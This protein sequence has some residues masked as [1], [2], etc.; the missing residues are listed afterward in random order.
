[1]ADSKELNE[2]GVFSVD[3]D[4]FERGLQQNANKLLA[5]R[6]KESEEKRLAKVRKELDALNAKIRRV[7][8]RIDSR[9]TKISVRATLHEQLDTLQDDFKRL[10]QDEQDILQR[11]NPTENTPQDF[12]SQLEQRE[13]LIRTGQITPFSRL[14]SVQQ[15]DEYEENVVE[16][17]EV[18]NAPSGSPSGEKEEEESEQ[19]NVLAENAVSSAV[20]EATLASLDDG[21]E[22]VYRKRLQK[23]CTA[24]QTLREKKEAAGEGTSENKNSQT[25]PESLSEEP[26]WFLPHP[27]KKAQVFDDGFSIPGDIRPKLFRYQ[28]TCILWLWE[29]Y[30][31]GAGGIIGDEMGLGK[32]VQIVAYLASLHYS[33]KFDKPT[34]VVCPATLMKQWVGEFHRWWAPFRVVILHS[35]GSGLNSKREGRDYKDSASEGEDE[36]EESVLEAEDERVNPLRR[37]SASFHKFAE[38]L[39]DSTFE[40]GHILI[41]TY[42]GLRI[43]SDLLLPREWGYCILDEGHKIRN[44]DAEISILSKQLRTVNRIILSGTPIQNNLTELWNLF[45]FIFPG[46]LGTLPVFQNQFALPINI[47]GYANATNIQVQTSYKCACMLRDLISPYLL[48]RMKLD[49]AADL[50]KKSEQVLFCKLTPEQRI[51][52]QQFL[53]SGDMNKILNGKR[54]VLFGVDVLRKICNHPDLVM[55]EFLEHKEGYEYGDPKKSGKLKVVQ[56][57]LKLWKSQNHRTLLFSQT[58]QMLDILEKAIGS[59]GDISYCRMDGTTSI[60]LRQGLV[61]EFNKTSRYDVFLLTTRVGGLGINLT[62]ADRVIIFD[63]DWNPSTDAQAR[64]RAWRLGQKRDVV[65]YRLM[66]SGTIEEKIYHRQIFKQFLTNKILKD[67]NQRRFFKMNDLHDLFTLDED[68]E[69]E[70]TATGDMF[71]GEERIFATKKK[72]QTFTKPPNTSHSQVQQRRKRKPRHSNPDDPAEF[73]K[74]EG[75]AGLEAYKPAEEEAKRLKKPKQ[76][77]TYGEESMLSGI[78]ASAGVKSSLEHD[79]LF[80]NDNPADRMAQQEANR[81]AKEAAQ[82]VLQSSYAS[83]NPKPPQ[84]TVPSVSHTPSPSSAVPSS[85]SL[86]ARLKRRQ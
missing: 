26:E 30:C 33:R 17:E 2:L 85:S 69:D 38:K 19:K 28:V 37:S 23:W 78:F 72:P 64:E 5:E 4:T 24:R 66:S 51:A 11:L 47:G 27:T 39:I 45:D 3:Q 14:D 34:L 36:E 74:L 21:D 7:E 71:L 31:Q 8:E 67:P 65:V 56:A 70:G 55:R 43:Y 40:R 52:Y 73:K 75:V 61:D 12:D 50:P 44:P 60:G 29:L 6:K 13:S 79:N 54:Q 63:P 81:I 83:R 46:R 35:T 42:A 10:K 84:P 25:Q 59:M 49:V 48:R 22:L 86:L 68:K 1:M 20:T 76:G 9:F 62:G 53:N 58:R 16:N 77:S 15:P 80:N 32:T 41:T 57:L 82:T 18:K